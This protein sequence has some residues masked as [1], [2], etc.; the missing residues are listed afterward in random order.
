MA[1]FTCWCGH[2]IRENEA[3]ENA[4]HILWDDVDGFYKKV[5]ADLL[6]FVQAQSQGRARAWISEY[7]G[8]LYP[9]DLS[10]GEVAEDIVD[11]RSLDSVSGIYRCPSC[12]RI[13]IH[14]K[15]TDNQWESF[16]P[17]ERVSGE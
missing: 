17:G 10:P 16:V 8:E 7:F 6:S 9:D 1:T 15:G 2:I 14:I 5:A 13:H 4:G 3:P 12:R 11:R